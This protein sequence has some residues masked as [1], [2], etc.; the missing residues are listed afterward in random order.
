MFRTYIIVWLLRSSSI[1]PNFDHTSTK[2]RPNF[3]TSSVEVWSKF[4]P[5]FDTWHLLHISN[6]NIHAQSVVR[7]VFV[8]DQTSTKLRPLKC[9]SLVEISTK[10]RHPRR[11]IS[12]I[13]FQ[14]N[15]FRK[16]YYL[17][18]QPFKQIVC[19]LV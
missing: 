19:L 3:D 17:F 13:L 11:S 4:R 7:R 15:V 16:I 14:K 6:N 5:N 10:L 9:R 12:T 1:R 2:L 8:L 18:Q